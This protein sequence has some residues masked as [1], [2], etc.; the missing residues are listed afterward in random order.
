MET[1]ILVSKLNA[2]LLRRNLVPRPR[3]IDQL[4]LDLLQERSFS[5]KLTLISAPAGYGKTTLAVTW[6]VDAGYR[7]AWLSVDEQDNDPAHFLACL[8]AAL[9]KVHP[10]LI[11]EGVPVG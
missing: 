9:N 1:N 6:V 11:G 2:P 5:R 10:D 8:V 3:L 4:C 7:F